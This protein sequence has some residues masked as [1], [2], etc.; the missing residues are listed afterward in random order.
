G[1][2]VDA[3]TSDYT[4]YNF[5]SQPI[6]SHCMIDIVFREDDP[7]NMRFT[8][9]FDKPGSHHVESIFFSENIETNYHWGASVSTPADSAS[10]HITYYIYPDPG[11][12]IIGAS[13]CTE[14]DQVF[15]NQY[16]A[17]ISIDGYT[18]GCDIEIHLNEIENRVIFPESMRTHIRNQNEA[19]A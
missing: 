10:N 5:V 14:G 4:A 11:F 17:R 7:N 12:D 9:N 19:L 13:T 3:E 2:L 1:E 15:L 8:V 16:P 6:E 18:S